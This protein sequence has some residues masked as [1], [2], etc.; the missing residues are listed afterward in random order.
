MSGVNLSEQLQ[1]ILKIIERWNSVDVAYIERDIVLSKLQSVYQQILFCSTSG[2]DEVVGDINNHPQTEVQCAITTTEVT[3]TTLHESVVCASSDIEEEEIS[4]QEK[5]DT[6]PTTE[7]T[8]EADAE[9]AEVAADVKITID[10]VVESNVQHNVEQEHSTKTATAKVRHMFDRN[11]IKSLYDDDT[12]T[13][14]NKTVIVETHIE[15]QITTSVESVVS[16][17][18]IIESTTCSI[19]GDIMLNGTHT[20]GDEFS[21]NNVTRDVAT[22]IACGNSL[23]LKGSIGINDK[24]LMLKEMFNGDITSYQ[25]TIEMLEEFSD[26]DDALIFIHDNF[27][28]NPNGTGVKLL[29]ELLNRKL[30]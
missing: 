2:T 8:V 7:D 17:A 20:I 5:I 25:S 9:S 22:S 4:E 15:E 29:I 30:S 1:Q 26:M 13:V 12:C 28:W 18:S 19:I 6:E 3:T 16:P 21:R 10:E 11:A 14:K 23:T 24:F 27:D